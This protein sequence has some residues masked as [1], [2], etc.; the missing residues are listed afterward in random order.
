MAAHSKKHEPEGFVGKHPGIIAALFAIAVAA[1]FI[2][3]LMAGADGG[4]G[5]PAGQH[6]SAPAH[7]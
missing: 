4:H 7:H 3:A 1:G 2:G 6:G 5:A